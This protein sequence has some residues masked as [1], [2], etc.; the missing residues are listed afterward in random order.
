MEEAPSGHPRRRRF[1]PFH[2][3]RGSRSSVR[4]AAHA[5]VGGASRLAAA[6]AVPARAERRSR[7]ARSWLCCACCGPLSCPPSPLSYFPP[8]A[9]FAASVVRTRR[10]RRARA[11]RDFSLFFFSKRS[12][13]LS[14]PSPLSLLPT[15]WKAGRPRPSLGPSPM[16]AR[17]GS[18][19]RRRTADGFSREATVTRWVGLWYRIMSPCL[20]SSAGASPLSPAHPEETSF[21]P[22]PTCCFVPRGS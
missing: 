1:L 13:P 12:L 5:V 18:E 10:L 7:G 14:L 3:Q 4:F 6:A 19:R 8:A 21:P 2:S 16:P 15:V 9:D 17:L 22:P 11:P 20:A